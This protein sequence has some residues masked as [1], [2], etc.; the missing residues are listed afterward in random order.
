MPN[1]EPNSIIHIGRVPFDNSYRHT[2]TFA[3]ATAQA[4]YF[5]SVCPTALAKEDYT[6]VRMNNAIRVPFNA[7]TLYTYNYV[8]YKNANY[9]NKWFYAFIVGVNYVNSKTTELLLEIDVMQTWYFDYELKACYVEREH[10]SDDTIGANTVPEPEMGMNLIINDRI[11]DT[12]LATRRVVVQ[13][14]SEPEYPEGSTTSRYA[15]ATTGGRY[16]D[17]FSG[18]AYYSFPVPSSGDSSVARFLQDLNT[19]GAADAVSN[20]FMFPSAYLPPYEGGTGGWNPFR[21]SPNSSAPSFTVHYTNRP[22]SLNGY[23]PRNNKLFTHPYCF[24]RMTDNNGSSVDLKYE[25]WTPTSGGQFA[26]IPQTAIDPD[27]TMFVVPMN[28]DGAQQNFDAALTFPITV[29]C[30]WTYSAYQ[31][32]SAQNML[33]NLITLGTSAAMIA[34]PAARGIGTAAKALGAGARGAAS[35]SA[36]TALSTQVRGGAARAASSR[37]GTLDNL[38]DMAMMQMGAS[39]LAGFAGEAYRQEMQPNTLRGTGSAN[40][41]FQCDAQTYNVDTMTVTAEYARIWDEFFDMYG[42]EVDRVKV[43][44]RTGRPSWNYV[45]CQNACNHG[46]V[47]ADHM[48]LINDIYNT[49]VTFWHTS[50]VGNYSLA[51]K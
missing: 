51:N 43:P 20:V 35:R 38:V 18:A 13:T 26:Y 3:N 19:A 9:G 2:M 21:L 33:S 47:P 11:T 27:A 5:A 7:E 46:N 22:A 36:S 31:T 1:F 41:L 42:Y 6:Y 17:L 39:Q 32:W 24:C 30:P 34:I 4:D 45:K 25:L 10:V 14:T 12:S 37:G 8:M 50:D 48:A 23:T 44:N 40:S 16:Q 29:K 15:N 28:Y 49:G